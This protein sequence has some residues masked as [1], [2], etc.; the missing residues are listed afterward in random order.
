VVATVTTFSFG[1]K[2]IASSSPAGE[3]L[4]MVQ[5]LSHSIPTGHLLLKESAPAASRPAS[6]AAGAP[7]L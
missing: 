1:W 6:K 7:F 4:A 5:R 3:L 2:Q